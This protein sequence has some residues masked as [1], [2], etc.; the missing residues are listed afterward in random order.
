M[1]P[2]ED[3]PGA[4]LPV[5]GVLPALL[6][7]LERD[8]VSVLVAPP[9]SGKTTLTP[10]ALADRVGGKVVVA[11]PRRVAARAAARRMAEISGVKV[12]DEIGYTVRGDSKT[13]RRTRVEV[14]T[15]GVL[16]Q[17]MQRDPELAGVDAVILDECHERHLDTDLALAF[18]VDV[19]AN[20]RD[21]LMLLATSAT[22]QAD[23][24]AAVLGEK[25]PAPVLTAEASPH[26]LEV[27]WS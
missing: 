16:V 11:E 26:P 15:T 22:A 2:R 24:L 9:G 7:A 25:R 13:S 4:E 20:L 14:V 21:D 27:V 23:R 17:R 1:L 5:R 3:P 6:E 10:L 12:A 8:G 18:L 19:R